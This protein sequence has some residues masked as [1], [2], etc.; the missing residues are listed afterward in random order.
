ML[1]ILPAAVWAF[2]L[3]GW[4][5]TDEIGSVEGWTGIGAVVGLVVVAFTTKIELL[6]LGAC[7][8]LW[9]A[10][11][12]YPLIRLGMINRANLQIDVEIM[13]SAYRQLDEKNNDI[14]AKV[15]LARVLY[16]RG[17]HATAIGLLAEAVQSGPEGMDQEA[18]TLRIW[19]SLHGESPKGRKI[20]CLRCGGLTPANERYCRKCTGPV[21]IYEAGGLNVLRTAPLKMFYVWLITVSLV[22]LAPGFAVA[23]PFPVAAA[24]ILALVLLAVLLMHRT[25]RGAV[26]QG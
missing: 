11:V 18:R 21:L 2:A 6:S 13:E 4:M 22:I 12:L 24:C 7:I 23:L 17:A 26:G 8:G 25:A 3:V 15:Q 20:R 14:G 9:V 19:Q 10:G 16:K 5:I 1:S